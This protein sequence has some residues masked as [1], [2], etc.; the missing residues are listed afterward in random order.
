MGDA[1]R[2]SVVRGL[3]HAAAAFA[4]CHALLIALTWVAMWVLPPAL[5]LA[6]L[7]GGPI[8]TVIAFGSALVVRDRLHLLINGMMAACYFVVWGLLYWLLQWSF[9]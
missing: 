6:L 1:Q 8:L 3:T 4:V 7:L 9:R 2:T 5:F